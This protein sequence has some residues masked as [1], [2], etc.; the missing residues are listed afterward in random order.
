MSHAPWGRFE[1]EPLKDEVRLAPLISA[2]VQAPPHNDK[3]WRHI[4]KKYPKPEGGFFSKTEIISGY[5]A[6]RSRYQWP[7]DEPHFFKILKMK[8]TR[9][10][11]GV[12]PV[13]VLTKPYPCP[14][15]C[16]FCPN[17]VRMPKSYLTDEPGAQRAT[18]NRFDPFAQTWN[19]LL[20]LH[21]MGHPV[22]K[23][24]L[25]VLGGT[26]SSYPKAYQLYFITR[27]FEAV[28]TFDPTRAQEPYTPAAE[29]Q[30]DFLDLSPLEASM[31]KEGDSLNLYNRIVSRHLRHHHD[32]A[33]LAPHEEQSWDRL[34]EA[35]EIN[36][37]ALCRVVGLVVETRPDEID[38]SE[39]LYLRRLGATKIQVGIQ[40]LSDEVL[41]LNRR[42]HD[43]Q[44][45]REAVNLLRQGGFKIHAHWMAN[46]YGST[47][48]ADI[49]D[50]EQL[51][52]DPSM[53]PDELKL[54][55]CSLIP[56]TE[57]MAHYQAE[58]WRPYTRE[59]LLEL[60]C[61][62]LPMSPA[63]C[64]LSRVI[65]DIPSTA[66]HTGNQETN[67]REVVE[68][69]LRERGVK[70]KEIRAREV[71]LRSISMEHPPHLK[72][73]KYLTS[74]SEE[75]F[76]SFEHAETLFG[77][78]RLSLPST[79]PLCEELQEA[80]MI[81][82]V[83]VYGQSLGLGEESLGRVQHRGL[84]R[85]LIEEATRIAREA[86]YMKLAV[87]SAIGTK[88]YYRKLGFEDGALYQHLTL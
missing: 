71:K 14:G 8:P 32:G 69:K 82:E 44:Q 59:E 50:Y 40:S 81:R 45:A 88:P 46:L 35:H 13:T 53:C 57:L 74:V 39:V 61:A 12:A 41:R 51:F 5:R 86:G 31:L 54:Y 17:D 27:L 58:R 30:P 63:Y 7:I 78:C 16:I 42:G 38:A 77:F 2:V 70:L 72:Q 19:R 22:E 37:R 20:A 25:I 24:E 23:V 34:T 80:A 49:Q 66:I 67:F 48:K 84:G 87:I 26:W 68:S 47:V 64:R 43:V 60:L 73:L 11:S 85:A 9:T 55:P 75:H 3:E 4:L 33:L 29:H 56:N 65:R 36:E 79:A 1:Y 62:V 76:L 83:H 28:N 10:Q 21:R 18:L 15:Q 6:M 52:S